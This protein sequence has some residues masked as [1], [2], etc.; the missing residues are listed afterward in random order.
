MVDVTM[1]RMSER[2]GLDDQA[3]PADPRD[4]NPADGNS[5]DG[6]S[7][8]GNPADGNPADGNPPEGSPPGIARLGSVVLDTDDPGGLARFYAELLGWSAEE[9][10]ED[11]IYLSGPDGAGL[12]IQLS[13]GH[14]PPSWP[15]S[16]VPQQ[17]H[18]DFYV[19]DLAAS[20]ARARRLGARRSGVRDG[21][22][23]VTLIDPSGHPFCL[24][25]APERR[26]PPLQ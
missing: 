26:P 1:S 22:T 9:T 6:N 17:L 13:L 2:V 18:V 19:D 25:L 8:D 4:D 20:V 11:W 3:E 10:E 21:K 5:A 7:A 16:E 14:R 12:G 24:C 23:F 15:G